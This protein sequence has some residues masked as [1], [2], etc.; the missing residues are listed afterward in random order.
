MLARRGVRDISVETTTATARDLDVFDHVWGLRTWAAAAA[1]AGFTDRDCTSEY[2][3][4]IDDAAAC[5][6]LTY[7]VTF[8]ITAAQ[9]PFG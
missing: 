9:M 3:Q 6:A 8:F 7:T 1:A 5:G 2:Q 4:Q